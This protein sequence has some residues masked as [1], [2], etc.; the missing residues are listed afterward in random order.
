[1]RKKPVLRNDLDIINSS[2]TEVELKMGKERVVLDEQAMKKLYF[3]VL[4]GL[5]RMEEAYDGNN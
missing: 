3:L 4:V 2:P 1:M 5:I